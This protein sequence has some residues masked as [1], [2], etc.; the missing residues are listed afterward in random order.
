VETYEVPTEALY[1]SVR[2]EKPVEEPKHVA[3]ERI[4]SEIIVDRV[5]SY[6]QTG[7]H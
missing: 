7:R 3:R 2:L 6:G 4:F 5:R 1:G